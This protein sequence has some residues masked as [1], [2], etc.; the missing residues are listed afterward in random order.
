MLWWKVA[1]GSGGTIN[2]RRKVARD[3]KGGGSNCGPLRLSNR[4]RR[5]KQIDFSRQFFRR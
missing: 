5:P 3:K 1:G 4:V 2:L